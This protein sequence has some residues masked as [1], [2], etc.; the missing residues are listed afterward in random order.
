ME[1]LLDVRPKLFEDVP[2]HISRDAK[3]GAA[4]RVIC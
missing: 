4:Y 3:P 1:F 2:S